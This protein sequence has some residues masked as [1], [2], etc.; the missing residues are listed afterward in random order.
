MEAKRYSIH[1]LV[2]DN[3]CKLPKIKVNDSISVGQN[4]WRLDS[5]IDNIE[6]LQSNIIENADAIVNYFK[7]IKDSE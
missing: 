3:E 4:C 5:S 6:D 2:V 7:T 1:L